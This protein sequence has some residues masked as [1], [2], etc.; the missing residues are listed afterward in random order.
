M[1]LFNSFNRNNSDFKINKIYNYNDKS[2]HNSRNNMTN[3][4][5]NKIFPLNYISRNNKKNNNLLQFRNNSMKSMNIIQN[6]N[7][8]LSPFLSEKN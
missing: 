1:N 2:L 3:I 5:F 7:L 4:N 8:E 6:T